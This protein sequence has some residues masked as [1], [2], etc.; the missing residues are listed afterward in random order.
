[1]AKLADKQDTKKSLKQIE[2]TLKSLY[3]I[4]NSLQGNSQPVYSGGG[5]D[6]EA[7]F[8]KKP[9]G[10]WSCA[11]CE[12]GLNN[13]HGHIAD[14]QP[15]SKLPFKEPHERLSKVIPHLNDIKLVWGWFL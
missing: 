10:G 14:Y 1:M 9:L 8:A 12:K 13:L 2:S 5:S 3:D 15:W 6:D 4:V 11:S 7:M